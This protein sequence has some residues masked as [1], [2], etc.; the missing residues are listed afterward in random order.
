M[1]KLIDFMR[2]VKTT[3][4]VRA[5]RLR[6]KFRIASRRQCFRC[7]RAKKRLL[8]MRKIDET[9]DQ[10]GAAAI[11]LAGSFPNFA[12][13]ERHTDR[14]KIGQVIDLRELFLRGCRAFHSGEDIVENSAEAVA[15]RPKNPAAVAGHVSTQEILSR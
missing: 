9:R 14:K 7:A 5:K 3:E 11:K 2:S 12:R 8:A 4:I 15:N 10:V 1:N 6:S 13:R